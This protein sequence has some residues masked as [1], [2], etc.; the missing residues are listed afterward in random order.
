MTTRSQANDVL[1]TL[2]LFLNNTGEAFTFKEDDILELIEILKSGG[3][4][5][6]PNAQ[7]VQQQNS[8]RSFWGSTSSV[9]RPPK[10]WVVMASRACR[11]AI[12]IGAALRDGQMREVVDTLGN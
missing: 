4:E 12:M 9:P 7:N 10:V 1:L 6:V 8:Y 11:G 2:C 5:Y 3:A